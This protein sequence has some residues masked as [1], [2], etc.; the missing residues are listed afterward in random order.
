MNIP[1]THR[2]LTTLNVRGGEKIDGSISPIFS[3]TTTRIMANMNENAKRS[4]QTITV[5][6]P[7]SLKKKNINQ[8]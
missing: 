6:E 5:V 4:K 3:V 1:I 7:M 2:T 8:R